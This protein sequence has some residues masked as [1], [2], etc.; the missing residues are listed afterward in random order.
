MQG[1]LNGVSRFGRDSYQSAATAYSPMIE[2]GPSIMAV[3]RYADLSGRGHDPF[4]PVIPGLW[5]PSARCCT[6]PG[7]TSRC[8]VLSLFE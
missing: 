3:D 7:V 5:T 6:G 2:L 1:G 4:C 8:W